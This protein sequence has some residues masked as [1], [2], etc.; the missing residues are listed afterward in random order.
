M[1]SWTRKWEVTSFT[2]SSKTYVVSEGIGQVLGKSA[3]VYGCSCPSWRFKKVDIFTGIRP[4]CKHIQ[5]TFGTIKLQQKIAIEEET[6]LL[7][8]QWAVKELT[9]MPDIGME[10]MGD[11][12]L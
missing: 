5:A 6:R 10:A 1:A 7:L 3:T 12:S 11:R 9:F 4:P 2:D 8:D